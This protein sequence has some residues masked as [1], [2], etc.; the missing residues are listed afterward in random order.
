MRL[1]PLQAADPTQLGG[2]RISGRLGEGG[3]GIVYFGRSADGETA[4]IKVIRPEYANEAAFRTR[5]RREVQAAIRVAG[6]CTA[7]VLG[8]D[9]ESSRPYMV[10]QFVEGPT[11]QHFVD[12]RGPITSVPLLRALALG[13][14]EALMAIHEAGVVHRDLKP[15]N[16]ILARSGPKVIDFGVARAFDATAMT[17]A[18][19][20]VGTPAWMAPE[21]LRG[22]TISPCTDV[23]SW[24]SVVAFA[25][26]GRP[27]FGWDRPEALAYRIIHESPQL[28]GLPE[29]VLPAVV[30]ALTKDPRQR[31]SS[32]AM[33]DWLLGTPASVDPAG[34]VTAVLEETWVYPG[35]ERP[36]G[37]RG[38]RP[39]RAARRRVTAIAAVGLM[40]GV[41]LTALPQRDHDGGRPSATSLALPASTTTDGSLSEE[42]TVGASATMTSTTAVTSQNLVAATTSVTPTTRSDEVASYLQT[43]SDMGFTGSAAGPGI[44][45]NPQ[46]TLR[47]IIGFSTGSPTGRAQRVFFFVRGR[48]FI[49][50]DTEGYSAS[51][52]LSWSNDTVIAVSYGLYRESDAMC[53]PTGGAATV[54]F[55]WNG[56]RLEPVDPIPP[57]TGQGLTRR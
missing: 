1:A 55:Q 29:E 49:G 48:G 9:T 38:D 45:Y 36:L 41:A 4:A 7:R 21:Q 56:S 54:R 52:S 34:G 25:G 46:S 35:A 24:G 31:P 39:R 19:A 40:V 18:G 28:T 13:L 22:G 33:V 8:A 50:T 2:Y 42:P 23:F 43:M 16:V 14:A 10:T 57:S 26:L 37:D 15:S 47:A 3:M 53:C 51:I 5:F 17:Q 20:V 44:R 6:T 30:A 12:Q 32:K 27:P 11:L